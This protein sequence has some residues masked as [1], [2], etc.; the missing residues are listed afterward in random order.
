MGFGQ[1]VQKPLLV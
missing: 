1:D